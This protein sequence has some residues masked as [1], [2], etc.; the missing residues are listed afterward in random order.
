M[1]LQHLY[2]IVYVLVN[3]I[4]LGCLPSSRDFFEHLCDKKAVVLFDES[5]FKRSAFNRFVT[6]TIPVCNFIRYL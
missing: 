4:D 1:H 3:C 6:K 5:L 2:R